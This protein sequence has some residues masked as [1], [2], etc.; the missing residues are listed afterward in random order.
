MCLYG[1]K[2]LQRKSVSSDTEQT[3][4]KYDLTWDLYWL[5][6]WLGLPLYQI[7][8]YSAYEFAFWNQTA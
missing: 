8:E 1:R 7:L 6:S 2:T 5:V 3:F 4:T